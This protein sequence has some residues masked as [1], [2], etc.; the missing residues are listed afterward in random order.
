MDRIIDFIATTPSCRDLVFGDTGVVCGAKW[1]MPSTS[2]GNNQTAVR[3][4]AVAARIGDAAERPAIRFRGV[5][6]RN[7]P[8]SSKARWNP[9]HHAYSGTLGQPAE[10]ATGDRYQPLR[11]QMR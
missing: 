8:P 4:R 5:P 3:A 11:L 6:D 7:A 1:L 9:P 2:L 10:R